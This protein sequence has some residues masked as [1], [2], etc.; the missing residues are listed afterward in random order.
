MPNS[1]PVISLVLVNGL[2]NRLR[3]LRTAFEVVKELKGYSL[4][5]AW[6][7]EPGICEISPGEIFSQQFLKDHLFTPSTDEQLWLVSDLKRGLHFYPCRNAWGLYAGWLREEFFWGSVEKKVFGPKASL[8]IVTG[9]V[10][11]SIQAEQDRIAHP[12]ENALRSASPWSENLSAQV[13]EA[14]RSGFEVAFHL[15]FGEQRNLFPT[16]SQFSRAVERKIGAGGGRLA[17]VSADSPSLAEPYVKVMEDLGFRIAT[18]AASPKPLRPELLDFNR[19]SQA[20]TVVAVHWSTFAPEALMSL[21]PDGS[22]LVLLKR[23]GHYMLYCIRSLLKRFRGLLMQN[24]RIT[25]DFAAWS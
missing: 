16:P 25:L 5:F 1:D 6:P 24:R 21:G 13:E 14:K 23:P 15:R 19:L 20:A 8:L 17:V 18:S 10:L 11:G 4:R 22:K 2:A 3:A 7:L 12:S 9:G